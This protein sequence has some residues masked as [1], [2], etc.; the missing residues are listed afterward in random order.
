MLR[1][2][3]LLGLIIFFGHLS[4]P[5]QTTAA[6][7]SAPASPRHSLTGTPVREPL[8]PRIEQALRERD[9]IIRNLLERVQQLED[10][11]NVVN[12]SSTAGARVARVAETTAAPAPS[13]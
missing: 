1:R 13:K 2:M 7:A 4:L 12:A 3:L 9:A 11:L 10:R 6:P 8:D 5:A